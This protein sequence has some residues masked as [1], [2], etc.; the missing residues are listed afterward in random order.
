[1]R[2]ENQCEKEKV[3]E[4][5]VEAA[6]VGLHVLQRFQNR[7]PPVLLRWC[8]GVDAREKTTANTTTALLLVL[9]AALLSGI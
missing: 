9:C 7:T 6:S 3:E 5:R 2:A 1:M 8:A 4:L